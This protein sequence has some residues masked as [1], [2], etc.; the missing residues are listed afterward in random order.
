MSVSDSP[1]TRVVD[2]T[3][4]PATGHWVIDPGHA[5]VGFIGR[6][7]MLTKVRGRFTDVAGVVRV[8]DDPSTSSVEVE[9]GMASVSSGSREHDEHLRSEDLFDVER[10]P[11]ATFASTAVAWSGSRARVTGDLTIV[12]VTRPV[13][14][15]VEFVGATRDPKGDDRAVYSASTEINREDWGLTWNVALETGGVLV[16][17]KIRIEVE[18]ETVRSTSA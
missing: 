17:K 2:G 4:V 11:T 14:L 12:G 13:A 16:S 7:F 10:H 18:V 6:H 3:E 5:E 15:D 8:G 9:I 1:L